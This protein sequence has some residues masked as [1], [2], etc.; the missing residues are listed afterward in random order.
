MYSKIL[1]PL[2]GSKTAE[3]VLPYSK[4][5][6]ETL[7]LP[8]QIVHAIDPQTVAPAVQ[9]KR[10]MEYL[11][12]AAASCLGSLSADCVVKSGAPGEIIVDTASADA[13]ALI[14]MATHGQSGG[15]RWLLGQVA[16]KVLQA[17]KNPLV[18][19]RPNDANLAASEGRFRTIVAP[20]DGSHLAEQ[21]LPHVVFLATQLHSAVTLI[22]TYALPTAGYFMAAGISHPNMAALGEKI[23]QEAG[24]YLEAKAAELKAQGLSKISSH[25]VE[26]HGPEEIIELARRNAD[27]LIA[28][29]SHGR[30]GFGRWVL[31][32]VAE[33]VV[34]YSGAPVLVI[35][36]QA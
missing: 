24:G 22:R 20:L 8:V 1:V 6:A 5:L 35:R 14:A 27:S 28:L 34:A 3:A 17:A 12:G 29:A 11:Q 32:S 13:G 4:F 31:G 16:Q 33:R 15:Q 26:G 10:E 25:I 7:H 19:I 9:T 2:D 30:S 23:K 21:V 36:P 18:L